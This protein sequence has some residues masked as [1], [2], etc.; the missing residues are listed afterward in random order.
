MNR[1]VRV[2]VA[3]LAAGVLSV[4]VLPTVLVPSVAGASGGSAT[5]NLELSS[6]QSNPGDVEVSDLTGTIDLRNLCRLVRT[7]DGHVPDPHP[8]EVRHP[9]DGTAVD[10]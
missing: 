7:G 4:F 5:V 10:R 2:A 9:A 1:T 6:A 3:A 8:G